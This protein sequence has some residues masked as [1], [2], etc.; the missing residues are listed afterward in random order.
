MSQRTIS[1]K[2]NETAQGTYPIS[3]F[4]QSSM[5]YQLSTIIQ[6]LCIV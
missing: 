6:M 5:V 3:A 2:I 4:S 1:L